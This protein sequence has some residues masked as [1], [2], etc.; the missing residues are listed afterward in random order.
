MQSVAVA[1]SGGADST[2]LLAAA[3]DA[4]GA[5]A[6]AVTIRSCAFPPGETE[7]A[8]RF[9]KERGIRQRIIDFDPLAVPGFAENPPDRC[10]LCKRA[11]FSMICNFANENGLAHVAEG[12]NTDDDGDYRPGRRALDEMGV[13][14]PL[15]TA[16]MSKKDV[17]G[18]L[19]ELG[20]A[21][22]SK[23]SA[24]CLASRFPYGER[25]TREGLSRVESSERFV[26]ALLPH[27]APLRVRSHGDVARIET[28]SDGFQ[29]L[30]AHR[31]KVAAGLKRLGF[32]YVALD[33]ED[34]RTGRM[35]DML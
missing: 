10:Y 4:L 33:L 16:G 13:A 7:A 25:I 34:Y 17:R 21:V 3:H 23:P 5:G 14:S 9:C 2:L 28:D 22:W 20:V 18:A 8:E 12:S 31:A 26:A 11:M 6:I 1:F 15:R 27:N 19:R 32:A 29:T 30:S 24:A 35:N